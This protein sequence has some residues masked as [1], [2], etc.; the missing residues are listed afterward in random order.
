[1]WDCGDDRLMTTY[2]KF[3]SESESVVGTLF[4]AAWQDGIG[5]WFGKVTFSTLPPGKHEESHH[6]TG[7]R[8]MSEAL[9]SADALTAQYFPR[10]D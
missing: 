8:T 7:F 4:T 2:T 1:M 9:S 3:I 10:H 6:T 5:L